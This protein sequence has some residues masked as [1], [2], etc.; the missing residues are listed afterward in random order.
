MNSRNSETFI[1]HILL[2]NISDKINLTRGDKYIALSNLK[3]Y[4]KSHTK[5]INLKYKVQ[6]GI[7]NLNYL[8][9]HIPHQLYKIIMS[10]L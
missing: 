7:I 5:T 1:S 3:K 6:C 4:I 2:L 8:T 9:D 10:I